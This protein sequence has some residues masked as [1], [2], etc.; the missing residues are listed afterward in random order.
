MKKS[1]MFVLI[2]MAIATFGCDSAE[3]VDEAAAGEKLEPTT[4]IRVADTLDTM[5]KIRYIGQLIDMYMMDFPEGCP[6]AGSMSELQSIL[7]KEGY[8]DRGGDITKDGFGRKLIYEGDKNRGG[9][10]Y[11]ISSLGDDGRRGTE[12]DIVWTSGK[13]TKSPKGS[14][15]R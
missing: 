6:K 9:R 5:N 7:S 14:F 10:N 8:H 12:D 4:N 3:P 15:L 2:L 13:F 1:I 11:K